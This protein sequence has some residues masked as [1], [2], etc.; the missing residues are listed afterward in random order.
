MHT[1]KNMKILLLEDERMLQQAMKEYLEGSGHLLV[2]CDDG[3]DALQTVSEETFDLLILDINVPSLDG[4]A[5][6][7]A[8]Q[9][10][11]I[12]PPVLFISAIVD[13]DEIDKAF[14]LGCSD[15]LKKPF[16]LRE[17]GL[18]IERIARQMDKART[19][20]VALGTRTSYDLNER[21]L[22]FDQAPMALSKRQLQI[23]DLLARNMGMT[24]DFDRFRH[25]VWE[26]EPVDNATIRAEVGR[27]NKSLKESFIENIRGVGYRIVK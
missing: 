8:L 19:H 10:L 15:Y 3:K 26:D 14:R 5:L 18:R 12:Q 16:H 25:Y 9:S 27:L 20:H 6:Y 1:E 23:I 7:E 4:L 2:C 13:I 11:K 24:V 22:Y 17:L 21:Q